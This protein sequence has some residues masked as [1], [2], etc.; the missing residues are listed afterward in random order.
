MKLSPKIISGGVIPSFL[1]ISSIG[2][3]F[4]IGS[5]RV[6]TLNPFWVMEASVLGLGRG[7]PGTTPLNFD[8]IMPEIRTTG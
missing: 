1:V 8:V 7:D 5:L 2:P 6:M 3:V 4:K